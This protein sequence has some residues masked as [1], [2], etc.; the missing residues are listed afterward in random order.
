MRVLPSFAFSTMTYRNI[1]CYVYYVCNNA[2]LS[3]CRIRLPT[4]FEKTS[5]HRTQSKIYE[6]KLCQNM[7]EKKTKNK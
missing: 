4:K 2:V 3:V 1:K 5:N 6:L 7:I